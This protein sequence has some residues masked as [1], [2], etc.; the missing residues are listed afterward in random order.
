[1]DYEDMSKVFYWNLWEFNKFRD[2]QIN[3]IAAGEDP[4]FGLNK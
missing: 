3:S 4:M 2:I 1:M